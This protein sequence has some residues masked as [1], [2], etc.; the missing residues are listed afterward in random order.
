[1]WALLGDGVGA[2]EQGRGH[3]QPHHGERLGKFSPEILAAAIY[4]HPVLKAPLSFRCEFPLSNSFTQHNV[5][6]SIT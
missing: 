1:M 5:C 2:E 4:I 3:A 6:K